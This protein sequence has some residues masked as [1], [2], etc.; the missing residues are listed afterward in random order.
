[1]RILVTGS[2]GFVGRNLVVRLGEMAGHEVLH[3]NRGSPP[4]LL[5]EQVRQA[6]A[7]V[8]L[9]GENRPKEQGGFA[10]GNSQLTMVL[11]AAIRESGRKIPLI[12]SSTIQA[13]MPNPYG[14]S[15]R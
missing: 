15:K 7:I 10:V 12:F 9:A 5:L 13:T 4:A 2:R 6:D 14:Q 8:H 11:C 1:M 3:F